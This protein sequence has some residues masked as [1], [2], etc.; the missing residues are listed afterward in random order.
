MNKEW[1]I[2]HFLRRDRGVTETK[3]GCADPILSRQ[4]PIWATMGQEGSAEG[5]D[6]ADPGHPGGSWSAG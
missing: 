4:E 1:E 5:R 6:R 2:E 3:K